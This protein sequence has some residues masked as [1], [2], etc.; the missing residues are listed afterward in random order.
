MV[1]ANCMLLGNSDERFYVENM[2]SIGEV[3]HISSVIL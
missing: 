2:D 3:F 1:L